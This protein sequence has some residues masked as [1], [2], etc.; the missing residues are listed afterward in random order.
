MMKS[1]RLKNIRSLRDTGDISLKPITLLLGQNSSGK[2][3]VLRT[4]PLLMQSIQTRSNAPILWYGDLVDFGSA[5]EVLSSFASEEA[6]GFEINLGSMDLSG[7]PRMRSRLIIEVSF[8]IFLDENEGKTNVRGYS[9]RLG[10]DVLVLELDHKGNAIKVTLNDRDY[11]PTNDTDNIYIATANLVPQ[12]LENNNKGARYNSLYINRQRILHGYERQILK[13]FNKRLSKQIKKSTIIN[14]IFRTTYSSPEQFREMIIGMLSKSQSGRALASLLLSDD[15]KEAYEELRSL[16]ILKQL[17]EIL[18]AIDREVRRYIGNVSY[19]GPSRATGERYYRMQELAID[20]IDPQGQNLAMF[21]NSLSTTKQNQFSSWLKEAIG[22]ELKIDRSVGHIQIRLKE[23]SSD[24]YFNIADMGYGFSQVLPI[25][26]QV[27]SRK[28]VSRGSFFDRSSFV[29][30]EQPELHLH[31][32][33]Q[34]GLADIFAK[35][36]KLSDNEESN[37]QDLRFVIETH[38]EAL[39]NRIGELIYKGELNS[40]HV[41]IYIFEKDYSD[42]SS[43]VRHVTFDENGILENWPLGFFSATK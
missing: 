26:A 15:G 25:L 16:Y 24:K 10:D 31:P 20:K 5:K 33:Y 34:A 28:Y 21:L 30:M 3:T 8:S 13:F 22:Y 38:S 39:I 14:M 6:I 12:V 37:D 32:A 35:S 43:K 17:P 41:V 11:T 1:I 23:Q 19:V 7:R 18:N 40:D 42:G 9:L 27:W 4:L 29:V 2:S 36:I